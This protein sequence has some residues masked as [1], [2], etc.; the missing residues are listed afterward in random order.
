MSFLVR[1]TEQNVPNQLRHIFPFRQQ[2]SSGYCVVGLTY[3]LLAT[4]QLTWNYKRLYSYVQLLPGFH[5]T[6]VASL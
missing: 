5:D 6:C 4:N 2:G 3:M 1:L